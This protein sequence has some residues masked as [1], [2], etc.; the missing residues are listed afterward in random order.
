[1][2]TKYTKWS[3]NIPNDHKIH[4]PTS[5]IG[6]PPKFTQ[7]GFWVWKHATWK[8]CLGH[9]VYQ[10][11]ADMDSQSLW[12]QAWNKVSKVSPKFGGKLGQRQLFFNLLETANKFSAAVLKVEQ[13]PIEIFVCTG[14]IEILVCTRTI[15]ILFL[16]QVRLR[17]SYKK[18]LAK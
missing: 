14:T 6:N 17:W 1:M 3:Q 4:R 8:S 5:S 7:F 11:N 15:E 10:S 18:I 13:T 16:A 2:A 9:T 12:F